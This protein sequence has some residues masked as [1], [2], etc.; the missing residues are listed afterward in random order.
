MAASLDKLSSYL[1]STPI[2]RNHFDGLDDERFAL[3]TRKGVFPD[4]YVDSWEKLDETSLPAKKLFF[5][6]LTGSDISD[7]DYTHAQ[8]VW[9]VIY[10]SS[11]NL[12]LKLKL[13]LLRS[14]ASR[15]LASPR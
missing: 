6:H 5:S 15:N 13:R 9:E 14:F 7:E 3:L 10:I 12:F 1:P 8:H 4:E 2:T 11:M